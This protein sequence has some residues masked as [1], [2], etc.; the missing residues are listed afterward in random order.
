MTACRICKNNSVIELLYLGKHPVCNKFL[1]SKEQQN[2]KFSLEIGICKDCGLIQLI[3]PFPEHELKP[4]FKWITYTEPEGHL[5]NTTNILTKLPKLRKDAKILGISFKDDSL[6]DRMKKRGFK[7]VTRLGL[8][9]DLGSFDNI[10]GIETIQRLLDKK[11]AKNIIKHIGKFDLILARHVL[12]HA[13]DI[14]QFISA[15]KELINKDGYIMFEVP[16]YTNPFEY[17]DYST[18]WEEHIVYFTPETYKNCFS[19]YG[20]EIEKFKLYNYPL[21]NSLVAIVKINNNVKIK[22]PDKKILE[23]EKNRASTFSNQFLKIK[24]EI[25]TL[26]SD[27]K[28]NNKKIVV[29]GAGHNACLLINIFEL[30]NFIECVIDDNKNKQDFLMPGSKLP[31]IGSSV[32]LNRDIKLCIFSLNPGI[33]EKIIEKN[34]VFVENGGNFLSFCPVSKYS[35]YSNTQ[36]NSDNCLNKVNKEVYFAT[37][38]VV[39]LKKENIDFLKRKMISNNLQRIRICAHK[40]IK[41]KIHEMFIVLRKNAYI[42]PHKHLNKSESFHLIEG[43]AKVIIFD[44][45]GK[46]RDV[47][48]LSDYKSKQ[49]FYYRMDNQYYHTVLVTSNFLVFHETTQG[50]FFKSDTIF[51]PWAP[52]ERDKNKGK[53]YIEKLSI[54]LNRFLS[55]CKDNL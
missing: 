1:K 47:I 13:Y 36:K 17:I 50:P 39:K 26:F 14:N 10:G 18:I 55:T 28:K 30:G 8:Q 32:L 49:K 29:F 41:N 51:A 23:N 11:R 44:D 24:N 35:I 3:N 21:E 46:I 48:E 54:D 38:K 20:L 16:D 31:I 37:D 22:F 45:N 34:K 25:K 4:E 27:Y 6:L 19:N 7:N 33:E 5:D 42:R 40:D 15:V 43:S 52:D 12:E 9:K 2:K 53:K